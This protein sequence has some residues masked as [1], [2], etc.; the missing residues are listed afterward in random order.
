MC[1][2]NKQDH[3]RG[4]MLSP[5]WNAVRFGK[6]EYWYRSSGAFLTVFRYKDRLFR[7]DCRRLTSERTLRRQ[8]WVSAS[9]FHATKKNNERTGSCTQ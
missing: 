7:S 5:Y 2:G 9:E 8:G 3:I 1:E 4:R 6:A